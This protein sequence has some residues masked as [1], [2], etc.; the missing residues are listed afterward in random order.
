M[1]TVGGGLTFASAGPAMA[2]G[3]D[4]LDH[5]ERDLRHVVADREPPTGGAS[6]V[7][8][9]QASSC[10]AMAAASSAGIAPG[11]NSV[12]PSSL[13]PNSHG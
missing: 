1:L 7:P 8:A 2:G 12:V 10:R 13:G 6:K 9:V 3:A 11:P 4:L 5:G